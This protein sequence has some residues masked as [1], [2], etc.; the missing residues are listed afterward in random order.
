MYTIGPLTMSNFMGWFVKGKGSPSR[1]GL[2]LQNFSKMIPIF[3]GGGESL[4]WSLINYYLL[5]FVNR[6]LKKG[7]QHPAIWDWSKHWKN[8]YGTTPP[9]PP[10]ILPR[11]VEIGIGKPC[12]TGRL[13]W[14]INH[15][16]FFRILRSELIVK[17][18]NQSKVSNTGSVHYTLQADIQLTGIQL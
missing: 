9:L 16:F 3:F 18:L 13:V 6:L 1:G 10:T 4:I 15:F 5:T 8:G 7:K 14:P 17:K 12:Q 2:T 11:F